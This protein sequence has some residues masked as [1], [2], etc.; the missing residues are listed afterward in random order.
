MPAVGEGWASSR[1]SR[2][3]PPDKSP[4]GRGSQACSQRLEMALQAGAQAPAKQLPA[5]KRRRPGASPLTFQGTG[6]QHSGVPLCVVP[7][8]K[9]HILLHMSH[10]AQQRGP[11]SESSS[12]AAEALLSSEGSWDR[13][14]RGLPCCDPTSGRSRLRRGTWNGSPERQSLHAWPRLAACPTPASRLGRHVQGQTEGRL[15]LVP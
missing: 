14:G 7:P 4:N 9:Q 3:K 10:K 1:R 11:N 15:R 8:P 12:A 2:G 13:G 6:A 5:A